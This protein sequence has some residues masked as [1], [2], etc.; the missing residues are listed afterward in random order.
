MLIGSV[1]GY[2]PQVLVSPP[3]VTTCFLLIILFLGLPISRQFLYPMLKPSTRLLLMGCHRGLLAVANARG[4]LLM[5]VG[6]GKCSRSSVAP[7]VVLPLSTATTLVSFTSP[8]TLSSTS[9]PS[10]LRLTYTSSDIA[11][12]LVKFMSSMFLWLPGT[13]ISSPKVCRHQFSRSPDSS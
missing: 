9:E 10:M 8:L 12:P 2:D 7:W 1:W 13:L 3:R 11:M 5:L 6:C 4:V